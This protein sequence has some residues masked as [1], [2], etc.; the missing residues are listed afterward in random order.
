MLGVAATAAFLMTGGLASAQ[1]KA[2]PEKAQGAGAECA[3]MTDPGQRDECVRQQRSGASSTAPNRES[4]RGNATRG[5][6]STDPQGSTGA[7]QSDPSSGT[8]SVRDRR[9]QR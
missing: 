1:T 5:N 6:T 7:S 8:G 2:A 9:Q 3:R 4:P